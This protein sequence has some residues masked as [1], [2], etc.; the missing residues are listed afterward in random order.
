[1]S[2][3]MSA[4]AQQTRFSSLNVG[5]ATASGGNNTSSGGQGLIQAQF[6]RHLKLALQPNWGCNTVERSMLKFF[7]KCTENR[8]KTILFCVV[9]ALHL[10]STVKRVMTRDSA[11]P[12][13]IDFSDKS[14]CPR[15][16]FQCHQH[17]RRYESCHGPFWK[18]C[19][20]C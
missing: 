16:H 20:R 5:K 8:C 2:C 18:L 9:T 10:A 1:M 4:T 13:K 11:L 12:L 6:V 17:E 19:L 15:H 7:F 3:S 14:S